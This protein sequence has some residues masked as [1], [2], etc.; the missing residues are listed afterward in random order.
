MIRDDIS[1]SKLLYQLATLHPE[2]EAI[3]QSLSICT[4]RYVPNVIGVYPDTEAYL[5][6]LNKTLVDELQASGKLFLSNAV[7]NGKYCLRACIVNFRTS[8]ADI[9]KTVEIIT[10]VG[11][12]IHSELNG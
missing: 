9:H 2:L 7:V 8:E 1:L 4:F 3:T 6:K 11:S 12:Q 5:N 10:R